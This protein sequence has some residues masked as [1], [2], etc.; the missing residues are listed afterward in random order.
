MKISRSVRDLYGDLLPRYDKLKA[1]V[2]DR[3]HARKDHRWHYESRL[4]TEESYAL[5]LETGRVRNPAAP[6]DFFACTV[7]VENRARIDEAEAAVCDLF[8]LES[9]RPPRADFTHLPPHSFDFDDLRLY[10]R[11]RD[12]S[13]ARPTGVDGTLFEV[14]IKTFLQHAWGIATHDFI[15]KT[16]DVDWSTSRIAYQVKAMLEN[17]ELSIAEA[18]RLTGSAMLSRTD[19][20]HDEIKANIAGITSRWDAALLPKDLRRL[21]Q[22]VIDLSRALRIPLDDLWGMVDHA[23]ANGKGVR[24]LN[25]S[26][27][28]AIIE[29]LI[30]QRGPDLFAPLGHP[31]CRDYVFVPLEVDV[32]A[33]AANISARV[34]RPPVVGAD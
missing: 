29:A 24:T 5:K 28:S 23:T 10:V 16:D 8:A 9:R 32:P 26:P 22:T 12:D 33:L 31:K 13:T 17:A 21:A 2:D 7:V 25:L 30:E 14:Q 1:L 6:E 11:W 20:G 15:Y 19:R 18:M 4:K 3:L 27:L 34:I